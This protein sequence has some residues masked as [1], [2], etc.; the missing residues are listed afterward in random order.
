MSAR[1]ARV[2]GLGVLAAALAG[3]AGG[4]ASAPNNELKTASDQS[5]QEKRASIR[6]QLAVGYFQDGK[7]EV[8][9]DEV[10]QAIAIQPDFADAYGVRALIYSQLGQ[11]ALADENFQRA[12]KLAPGNPELAN[13]YG[14]F[15]CQHGK[16]AQG[17]ALFESAL[18]NP[19]YASPVKAMLN[20][21]SCSLKM[22][23]LEAA[24]R[25]LLDALRYEPDHPATN[26]NLARVYY[27]RR[28]YTRAGFFINRVKAAAKLDSL[29]PD[30]LWLAM[31]IDRK[32]GDKASE[33]SLG[34]M[35]RRHH[36]GSP[37]YAAFQRGAF[38]E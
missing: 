31:R 28:D 17:I 22:K 14:S 1:I 21:G 6:L 13:N 12:I 5:P 30:V 8:A 37:E 38:D 36:P 34:T 19:A 27:E 16:G 9:L 23:N 3:C 2:V 35:L 11:T 29:S 26:A 33:A 10:K 7:L 4:G 24:E 25:Y 15:L 18:K 20:A 32:L